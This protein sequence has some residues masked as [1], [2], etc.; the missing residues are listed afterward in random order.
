MANKKKPP[1]TEGMRKTLTYEEE[2]EQRVAVELWSLSRVEERHSSRKL[3]ELT[4]HKEWAERF[5]LG[6]PVIDGGGI[7]AL[8]GDRGVG[9]TQMAVEYIRRYCLAGKGCLYERA[10]AIAMR[11]REAYGG[12]TSLTERQVMGEFVK[13]HLL[14][15]DEAQERADTDWEIRSMTLLLDMRYAQMKPTIFIANCKQKQFKMLVGAAITDRLKE[16]GGVLELDW[17][18]FRSIRS[19]KQE[20]RPRL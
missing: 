19:G 20:A 4:Q 2:R 16:G 11:L 12:R 15:I 14:V 18:S 17:P 10:R 9:K 13:P 8:L 7:L 1:R 5:E 3:K 6:K